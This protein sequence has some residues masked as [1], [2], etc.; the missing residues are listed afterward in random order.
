MKMLTFSNNDE[1]PAVGLG[2]WKSQPGEVFDAVLTALKAGYRHIDCAPIYGNEK[3]IGQAL[4]KAFAE[5]V[6]RREELWITSKLWNDMHQKGKV[7]PA[8]ERTLENLA[9][10]Y[11]DLWLIHWPVVLKGGLKGVPKG[12]DF[13]PLDEVPIAETWAGMEACVQ[14]GLCKHIGVSNF[15]R[16]KIAD[17]L[18]YAQIRPECNQVESHPFLQQTELLE[19]C[20]VENIHLTAY[21]PLGSRDRP[22]KGQD[23]PDMFEHETIKS[24]ASRHQKTPAQ[25]LIA[26]AVNRG[27]AV[28]PKSTNPD[29]IRMNLEAG[30]IQL[31]TE[32]MHAIAA[33][34]RHFRYIDG[35]FWTVEGSPYTLASL[36]GE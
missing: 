28:I 30:D 17:L 32:E 2:T 15:S 35:T 20:K 11:L 27:S 18:S 25:I 1:M 7:I 21:S 36:W 33:L 19:F 23:E 22:S 29:R 8:L 26:W 13:I 31:S 9:I 12:E 4:Q 16:Q 6:V 10:D 5:G 3:E 14:Q 24:I 34:D